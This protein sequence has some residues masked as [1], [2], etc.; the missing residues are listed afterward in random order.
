MIT[1]PDDLP[2][3]LFDAYIRVINSI[4]GKV[5]LHDDNADIAS[6]IMFR[7]TKTEQP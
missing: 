7:V 2:K 5:Y 1:P 3:N 6:W 4:H